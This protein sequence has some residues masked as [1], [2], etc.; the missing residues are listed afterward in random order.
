M[1]KEY[2]NIE[3]RKWLRLK[4]FG[5]TD[6][7]DDDINPYESLNDFFNATVGSLRWGIDL[8]AQKRSKQRFADTFHEVLKIYDVNLSNEHIFSAIEDDNRTNHD[9]VEEWVKQAEFPQKPS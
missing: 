8:G 3:K 5:T 6:H 7:P 9:V 1:P 4:Y 2:S